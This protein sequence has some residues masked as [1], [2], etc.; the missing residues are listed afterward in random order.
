MWDHMVSRGASVP[1]DEL[2]RVPF[3]WRHRYAQPT[4]DATELWAR[5]R[6]GIEIE[7]WSIRQRASAWPLLAWGV[8][9]VIV[10]FTLGA[11]AVRIRIAVWP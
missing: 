1:L 3:M 6:R 4:L 2:S 11:L 8:S 5:I 9:L 7:D 10:G